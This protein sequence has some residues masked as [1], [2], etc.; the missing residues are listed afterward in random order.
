MSEHTTR[1]IHDA[2]EAHLHDDPDNAGYM[3]SEYVIVYGAVD[4]DTLS[5][6]ASYVASPG[7]TPWGTAGLLVQGA[8]M[9]N[10]DMHDDEED[11]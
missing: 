5:H 7:G 11:A 1:A 8:D 9:L 4:M 3:L 2:I 10:A 6:H